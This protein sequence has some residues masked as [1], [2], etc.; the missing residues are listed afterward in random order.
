MTP[1]PP[2]DIPIFDGHNDL[3]LHIAQLPPDSDWS[4]LSEN[5]TAS[6]DL[7]RALKGNLVGGIFAIFTPPLGEKPTEDDI[8]RTGD[9]GYAF[10][11]VP[12]L[13]FETAR[14]F[15]VDTMEILA[16]LERQS[17]GE[18]AVIRDIDALRSRFADQK[19]SAVLHFEGAEAIDEDLELLSDYY[20]AGLRSLGIVWSRPNAFGHGVPFRYPCSPDTGPGLTEAGRRLVRACNEMGILLDLAHL[21][22]AGFWDVA[23][24]STHPL[25]VSHACCH[26]ICPS[27]RNLT[28][29]Q[30]DAI[31][32]SNGLVGINFFVGDLREDGR[33]LADTPVDVIVDHIDYVADR[34]GIDHVGFGS[35][36]DGALVPSDIGDATGLPR[37]VDALRRRGYDE[38]ALRKV[39]GENW[40]RV[41]E[42]SWKPCC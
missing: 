20:D 1:H 25:V 17:D 11:L 24:L 42:A 41:L 15:T 31:G 40:L 16:D 4:F 14:Q 37:L 10:P 39:A 3:L 36:F 7:P 9:G 23:G 13:P 33:F 38:A 21:N 34:V 5:E 12:A 6:I 18:F 26:A 19:M 32:E 2:T 30:I 22:E 35:D 27:A 29:R 8:E 28:D